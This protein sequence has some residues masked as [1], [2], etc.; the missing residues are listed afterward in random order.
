MFVENRELKKVKRLSHTSGKRNKM[1][2]PNQK[3]HSISYLEFSKSHL[4]LIISPAFNY[5][6]TNTFL[7]STI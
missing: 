1:N 2:L 6:L 3:R 4:L 5:S 7:I